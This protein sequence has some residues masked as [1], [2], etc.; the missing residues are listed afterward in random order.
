MQT[1]ASSFFRSALP[2]LCALSGLTALATTAGVAHAQN[3]GRV[4]FGGSATPSGVTTNAS[5]TNNAAAAPAEPATDQE[6]VDKE[7]A[8]RDRRLNEA[9]A[10][11]GPVGLLH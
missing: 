8:E 5:T 11:S 3:D 7:W 2:V 4:T 6:K 1:I 10:L 9:N